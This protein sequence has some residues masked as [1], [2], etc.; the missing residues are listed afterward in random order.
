M[1]EAS[2]EATFGCTATLDSCWNSSKGYCC[3]SGNITL[4][5]SRRDLE[6]RLAKVLHVLQ[7][8]CCH[9]SP[10]CS[11]TQLGEEHGAATH[12][13]SLAGLELA[14]NFWIWSRGST[15]FFIRWRVILIDLLL[16]VIST[17]ELI[18]IRKDPHTLPEWFVVPEFPRIEAAIRENPFPRG[19][20]SSF[21]F[22]NQ[23]GAVLSV[24]VGAL[25]TLFTLLPLADVDIS[26]R[27]RESAV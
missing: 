8:F 1:Q 16:L 21:P 22:S 3:Q 26:V 6:A 2:W 17:S 18:A 7:I 11:S 13:H 19:N 25:S 15:F 24:H 10:K 23:L 9:P 27:I 12:R 5:D 14:P 20:L 4:R